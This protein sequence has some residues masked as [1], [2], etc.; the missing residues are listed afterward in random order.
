MSDEIKLAKDIDDCSNCPL[1]QHDCTG[2]W[3]SGNG[4][5][6]EPPCCSWNEN[7]K[8]Y[9]GMYENNSY[10]PSEGDLEWIREN[11]AR[12]EQEKKEKH[13]LKDKEE[14]KKL[15][16]SISR[17]GN[18]KIKQGGELCYSWYCPRCNRW[19]H[20]WSESSHDGVVETSCSHCGEVLVHSWLLD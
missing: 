17:Y 19:F 12:K 10:E 14:A 16:N 3:T 6:V 5:P 1:Y 15:I 18:A 20:A 8:I 13:E 4:E 9:K 11:I 7:D 2:G